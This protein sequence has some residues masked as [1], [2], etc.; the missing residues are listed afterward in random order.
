MATSLLLVSRGTS[1][2]FYLHR[3]VYAFMVWFRWNINLIPEYRTENKGLSTTASMSIFV[4]HVCVFQ[5]KFIISISVAA[6]LQA[7]TVEGSLHLNIIN[8]SN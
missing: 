1:A 7:R 6:L 2:E 5:A 3:P 4:T 8:S